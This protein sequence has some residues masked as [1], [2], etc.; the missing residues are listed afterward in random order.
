MADQ[1]LRRPP[2]LLRLHKCP[3]RLFEDP[4]PENDVVSAAQ[5]GRGAPKRRASRHRQRERRRPRQEEGETGAEAQAKEMVV[6]G[7][8][9][10]V[11]WVH[12]LG[13]VVPAVPVQRNAGVV[14][15]VRDGGDNG[16]VAGPAGCEAEE[17]GPDGKAPSG[18]RARNR[19]RRARAVG[20]PP[21]RRGLV[22]E[23]ALGWDFRGIVQ[24]VLA[25]GVSTARKFWRFMMSNLGFWLCS[26][27]CSEKKYFV[28]FGFWVFFSNA[29]AK[30]SHSS[31]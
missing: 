1:V 5:E 11:H 6:R 7:Q 16:A 12:M 19:H 29:E 27:V 28:S 31:K 4:A 22:Q 21:V 3:L 24:K 23:E 13:V 17:G 25:F 10:L 2:Y 30:V 26:R 14:S 18:V 15:S 8:L 9:L 20:G